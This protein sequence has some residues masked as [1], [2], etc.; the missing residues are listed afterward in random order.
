MNHASIQAWKMPFFFLHLRMNQNV[1]FRRWLRGIP[2]EVGFWSSYY[3]SAKRRS[4]LFG[5]SAFCKKCQ[6][7][8]FD[9]QD[10]IRNL[11]HDNPLVVDLGC[12]LSYAMG[13][14]FDGRED[15]RVEYV[16]PL[17]PFY[18]RLLDKYRIDR[19]R[20]RFGMIEGISGC[21]EEGSVDL[22]HVRNALDHCANPMLGIRQTMACLRRGGIL[23]LNHFKNEALNEG[24]RGFHQWNID[25]ENGRLTIWN[26]DARIDV[27]DELREVATVSTNVTPEG[28]IVAVIEKTKDSDESENYREALRNSMEST[29]EVIE[30]FQ[31][32]GNSLSYQM[33]RLWCNT[34][35]RIMRLLPYSLLNKIK[36]LM[37]KK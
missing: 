11:S 27:A 24:Y 17:A 21:Y 26:D 32:S 10:Y 8:C 1:F 36:R 13:D 19:P 29:I 33:S 34:G 15:A 25:I 35:H 30:Y 16:D 9:V 31:A 12:A 37:S 22:I 3:G 14:Q 5:W 6:L 28:R 2:Y 23:Y 4:D 18:N 20:I 7:D